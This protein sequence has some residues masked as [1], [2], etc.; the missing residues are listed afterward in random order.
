M[1]YV[2]YRV[3]K[4]TSMSHMQVTKM[5]NKHQPRVIAQYANKLS[6]LLVH[7]QL[8]RLS[9]VNLTL[10]AIL[11]QLTFQY[12]KITIFYFFFMCKNIYIILFFTL[13]SPVKIALE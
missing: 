7:I 8:L 1:E 10:T 2:E 11:L 4:S 13:S 9:R 3:F 6:R 12:F 5:T